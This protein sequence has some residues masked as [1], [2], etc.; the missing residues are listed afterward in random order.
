[1]LTVLDQA[2]EFGPIFAAVVLPSLEN[3]SF[4]HEAANIE[5]VRETHIVAND[6]HVPPLQHTESFEGCRCCCGEVKGC[7]SVQLAGKIEKH[8][9]GCRQTLRIALIIS[10]RISAAGSKDVSRLK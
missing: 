1:M 3:D 7:H 6:A 9:S 8:K 2:E 5:G 10:F 4:L